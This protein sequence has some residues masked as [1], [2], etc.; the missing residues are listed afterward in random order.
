[1]SHILIRY[2][3]RAADSAVRHYLSV[4]ETTRPLLVQLFLTYNLLSSGRAVCI[5]HP[6]LQTSF[7]FHPHPTRRN[8]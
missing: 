7:G 6:P 3:C 2:N 8:R 1:M 5:S 4:P